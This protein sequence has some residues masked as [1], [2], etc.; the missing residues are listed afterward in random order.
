M[1]VAGGRTP[2]PSVHERAQS[3]KGKPEK[4]PIH[5]D[6]DNKEITKPV[7]IA[8]PDFFYGQRDKLD[9]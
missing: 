1:S 5:E 7:K 6:S 9:K 4:G 3:S 2:T 8:Q